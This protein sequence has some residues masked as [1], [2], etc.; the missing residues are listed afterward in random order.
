M[1]V[2]SYVSEFPDTIEFLVDGIEQRLF[3]KV[4]W[5]SGKTAGVEFDWP[6]C[7]QQSD[8]VADWIEL[9]DDQVADE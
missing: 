3:G 9:D 6:A 7:L 5:R 1:L 4:M 8:E 2:S